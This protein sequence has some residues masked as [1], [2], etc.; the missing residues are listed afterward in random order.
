M[1]QQQIRSVLRA[2][3]FTESE[4]QDFILDTEFGDWNSSASVNSDVFAALGDRLATAGC[5][6][7]ATQMLNLSVLKFW[8]EDKYMMKEHIS[9][10]IF[11]R[12]RNEYFPLYQAFLTSQQMSR[13]LPNGPMFSVYNFN[14]FYSGTKQVLRSILGV[15]GVPLSYVIRNMKSRPRNPVLNNLTSDKKI[16]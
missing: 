1:E 16:Y 15:G 9:S 2:C 7:T 10:T 6:V 12:E 3:G 14:E 13:T 4:E 11:R 5:R 8:V